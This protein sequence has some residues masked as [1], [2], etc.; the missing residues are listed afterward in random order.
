MFFVRVLF[1]EA[2]WFNLD[3]QCRDRAR[4]DVRREVTFFSDTNTNTTRNKYA[5]AV[6]HVVCV[7]C[8]CV[9]VAQA[10]MAKMALEARQK[11]SVTGAFG[12][13]ETK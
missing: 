7:G 1:A 13:N 6:I 2:D 12:G 5:Q 10:K 11:L 9:Q 3:V 4:V 8:P